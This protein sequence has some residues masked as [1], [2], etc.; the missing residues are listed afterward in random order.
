MKSVWGRFTKADYDFSE[1]ISKS[2]KR[3]QQ[4]CCWYEYAR[5]SAEARNIIAALRKQ[6]KRL[7]GKEG[8]LS[9][10]VRI[11]N[12]PYQIILANMSTCHG[13]PKTPW[14]CL[15]GKDKQPVL[16][17][18][19][20]LPLIQRLA[21]NRRSPPLLLDLKSDWSTTLD[22][23]IQRTN[24]DG[25]PVS[26]SESIRVGFFCLDLK[27][28]HEAVIESFKNYLKSFEREPCVPFP[29]AAKKPS[30][31]KP[32]GRQSIP[33]ALNALAAMRLRY[34]CKTSAEALEK[35]EDTA[36]MRLPKRRGSLN[37]A[38]DHAL[39]HFQ[40]RFGE[41]DFAK[42]IHYTKG[43]QRNRLPETSSVI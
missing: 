13:F 35:L 42:P 14:G 3:E 22:S 39:E 19:R 20:Q 29:S 23:W 27:C 41:I 5:E 8:R 24:K 43:W 18:V 15:S 38:C 4:A 25:P 34:H 37:R 10:G 21:E 40:K 26:G 11:H 12:Y 33:D 1:V 36:C 16:K 32:R 28:G 30:K 17:M 9:G 7:K 2:S 6:L 31:S